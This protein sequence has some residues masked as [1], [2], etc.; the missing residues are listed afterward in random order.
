VLLHANTTA[1]TM[2]PAAD[3]PAA[4]CSL[5]SLGGIGL[6]RTSRGWCGHFTAASTAGAFTKYTVKGSGCSI[7]L[8]GGCQQLTFSRQADNGI[9]LL[10]KLL[11]RVL[12]VL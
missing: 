3:A 12:A 5:L 7:V 4:K 10:Q 6:V 1:T 9:V 8:E 11:L 2:L